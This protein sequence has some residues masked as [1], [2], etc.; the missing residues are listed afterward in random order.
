MRPIQT[1]VQLNGRQR[2]L[3]AIMFTDM[4]GY[5]ALGQRNEALSLAMVEEQRR[6]IRPILGRHNGREVKTIGDA[7]LVEFPSALDAVRCAYEIQRSLHELNIS[8][9]EDRRIHLRVGIHLGD[10]VESQGDIS[11]DAVNLASRIERLAEDGG[12]CLTRQVYDQVQNKFEVP[13]QSLSA[14][15]L[16]N[17][18]L[19]VEVY[20][21]VLPWEG[22]M[23]TVSSQPDKRRIAILPLA[24]YSPEKSDEYLADG[25][26]EEMISSVSS[27]TDLTVIARTSAMS[28]KGSNKKIRE[29]G[30]E[31]EVGT[32]LEGSVRKSGN[33]LRVTVQLIDVVSQ[34]NLWGQTYDRDF[35][36]IFAVQSEISK[37]VAQVLRVRMLPNVTKHLERRPTKNT[38]A[39]ALYLKGRQ[40]WR[41]RTREGNDRAV[42]Y[43]EEAIKL[44]PDFALAYAGLADCY[45]IYGNYGWWMPR[46]SNQRAK[47][48]SLKAI[49][50]DPSI[51]EPHASL[52]AVKATYE[53][54]WDGGEAELKRAIELNPSY[55]IAHQ[56][57]SLQLWHRGRLAESYEE[58]KAASLL[59]PLSRVIS[60]NLGWILIALGR[61]KEATEYLEK[62][63][64]SEPAYPPA[65]FDLAWAYYLDSRMEDAI[66]EMRN[67]LAVSEG[68]IAV[69]C[70]LACLLGLA[71]KRDEA[72]EMITEMKKI[73]ETSYVDKAAIAFPLFCVGRVDEAFSYLEGAYEDRSDSVLVFRLLPWFSKWR[74]DPRWTSIERNLGFDTAEAGK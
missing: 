73:S 19:P 48:N 8:I 40:S 68:D 57:Y 47:E 44:D 41:D 31:L 14:K 11:G 56:W 9:P 52:A 63:V 39:Y 28:Y 60:A 71:G 67:A 32:I 66:S 15:A 10:V 34:T 24:N 12:V 7:F 18:S 26:T 20:K 74:E 2:R 6:L 17:V 21:M 51:A 3:A 69:Q 16:K 25:M 37:E 62:L 1:A 65:H 54:D 36:D 5:T 13:M 29:I 49:E 53:Y 42:R 22:A 38:E 61:L 27:I 55:A 30:A 64:E 35:D 45:H 23:P 58:I 4:V 70:D 72:N 59:D 33:R 43:L 50:L 46:E